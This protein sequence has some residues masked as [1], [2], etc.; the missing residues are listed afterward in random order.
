[1][2]ALV[3]SI[4]LHRLLVA[5]NAPNHT[6][7][8]IPDHFVRSS[9]N[10]PENMRYALPVLLEA[11]NAGLTSDAAPSLQEWI[12]AGGSVDGSD[13]AAVAATGGLLA[14]GASRPRLTAAEL[15]NI[16]Y[17]NS[18]R[19]FGLSGDS[20]TWNAQPGDA[21]AKPASATAAVTAAAAGAGSAAGFNSSSSS[22]STAAAASGSGGDGGSPSEGG[23]GALDTIHEEDGLATA[24][25]SSH[26]HAGGVTADVSPTDVHYLCRMCRSLL[27]TGADVRPH[28]ASGIRPSYATVTGAVSSVASAVAAGDDKSGA[29]AGG[30]KK[31]VKGKHKGGKKGRDLHDDDDDEAENVEEEAAAPAAKTKGKSPGGAGGRRRGGRK[32]HRG[33][34]HSNS[35][36]EEEEDRAVSKPAAASVAAAAD[37]SDEDNDVAAAAEEGEMHVSRWHTAKGRAV[38]HRDGGVCRQLLVDKQ[39]WMRAPPSE[40]EGVLSCPGCDAKVGTYSLGGLKCSCG[41]LVAPAFKVPRQRVDEVLTGVDALEAALAAA[42][43]G[44]DAEADGG[45]GGDSDS[46][47]EGEHGRRKTTKALTVPVSKHRGNFN[48]FRNKVGSELRRNGKEGTARASSFLCSFA[49]ERTTRTLHSASFYNFASRHFLCSLRWGGTSRKRWSS[50]RSCRG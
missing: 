38:R 25:E 12:A 36:D 6:P 1:M 13:D 8:N 47:E 30:G 41:L 22:S 21:V 3:P 10:E 49:R 24:A 15:A 19:F 39:P 34:D 50:R 31:K 4:P 43:L 46:D 26:A 40:P 45:A 5:S 23:S 32:G 2:R 9:R 18:A 17:Q 35:D 16:L 48:M 37:D 33:G 11:W 44:A 42:Q 7:Q 14:P 29:G 27:F 20:V 28:D